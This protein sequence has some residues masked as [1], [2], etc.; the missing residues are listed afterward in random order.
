MCDLALG[1]YEL[2]VCLMG[3]HL[4]PRAGV[5]CGLLLMTVCQ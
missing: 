4:Q 3:A 1:I 2:W 5:I